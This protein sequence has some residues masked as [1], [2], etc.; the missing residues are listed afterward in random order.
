MSDSLAYLVPDDPH[1]CKHLDHDRCRWQDHA[2]FMVAPDALGDH[3]CWLRKAQARE[4]PLCA[5]TAG[6]LAMCCR[7]DFVT[8]EAVDGEK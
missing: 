4:C 5:G 3:Y 1:D 7:S 2:C 6:R 8:M